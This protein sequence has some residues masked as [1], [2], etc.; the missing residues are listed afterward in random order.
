M[1]ALGDKD[2]LNDPKRFNITGKN[3][4]KE[5][6]VFISLR[7]RVEKHLEAAHLFGAYEEALEKESL[8]DY[9]DLINEAVRGLENDEGF[10]AQVGE[11]SQFVLA[12]EHQ[13]AN[14]A[15]NRLLELVTDFDGEP[16]LFIVGDEKQS[17]YRFQGA[18]RKSFFYFKEKYLNAKII[19]LIEN[20]RSVENI[21]TAAYDLIASVPIPNSPPH[22]VLNAFRGKGGVVEELFCDTPNVE[23]RAIH[24]HI[25]KLHESGTSYEDIAILTR[26]NPDVLA[27]ADS[28]RC[29]G[30]PEDHKSAEINALT[31][32]ATQL[33]IYL[34]RALTDLSQNAPLSRALF[35]PGAPLPLTERM[36]LL[37]L[38]RSGKLLIDI[39][40][41]NSSTEMSEWAKRMRKLS[42][43]MHSTPAVA[44]LA[45]L[46]MESG[47]VAG[48]LT[49][50]ESEDAYEAYQGFMEEA[51]LLTRENSGATAY[52]LLTRLAL[53]E[54][55]E[56][57][58]KRA[59]TQHA[60]VRIMTIHSAK[61][62]EF[63]HVIIA[64][65]TDEKMFRGKSSDFSLSMAK[66]DDEE[67]VRRLFYVAVTR[68][69][70]S[71]LITHAKTTGEDRTQTPLRFLSD[72]SSHQLRVR[73]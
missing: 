19:S 49:L 7:E 4:G 40:E 62:L 69:R 18:T 44:W 48:I 59:R 55:H 72:I 22:T 60:G 11:Q 32:P 43:E 53:I 23:N 21:L 45:R 51:A 15:Q 33:F 36:R 42:E 37:T 27:L 35:I 24:T 38:A 10:R 16:N 58:V 54:K 57:R 39:L 68:A 26:K 47:F 13:D 5:K 6:S 70:D 2:I 73:L 41:K 63:P 66:K 30:I 65:A 64:H 56:I 17:I 12:D 9:D 1:N 25:K 20:Y 71:I 8:Y 61:G 34:I 14:P 46:A 28:L 52:D 3:K 31:H 50:T 67:D 29:A